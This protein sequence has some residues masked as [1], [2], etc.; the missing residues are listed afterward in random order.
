MAATLDRAGPSL[1]HPAHAFL[2]AATTTL[3]LGAL[4]SDIAYALSYQIQWINFASWLVAGGLVTGAAAM[5]F[6]LFGLFDARRRS[7]PAML[8]LL[9]LAGTWVIGSINA[10]VHAKDA[11]AAMPAAL[12]LSVIAT[13]LALAASWL[14]F[15]AYANDRTGGQA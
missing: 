2:L 6:A 4:L 8:Y 7:G 12:V 9:L 1:L 5:V 11:W 3:F 10:L 14:G 13:A 15:S